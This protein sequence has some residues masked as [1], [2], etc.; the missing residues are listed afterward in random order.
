MV[1]RDRHDR[2]KDLMGKDSA[3]RGAWAC[4]RLL[5]CRELMSSALAVESSSRDANVKTVNGQQLPPATEEDR[6]DFG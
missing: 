4:S 6:G 2:G 5:S 1:D 3:C